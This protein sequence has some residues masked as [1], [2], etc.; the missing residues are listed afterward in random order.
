VGL[1]SVFGLGRSYGEATH[2]DS[3]PN[4]TKWA[5][6]NDLRYCL[7]CD[8]RQARAYRS[9][10]TRGKPKEATGECRGLGTVRRLPRRQFLTNLTS[11]TPTKTPLA[12]A[13]VLKPSQTGV[14]VRS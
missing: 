12:I 13:T 14:S 2:A 4:A 9:Y 10:G 5:T 3:S 1:L 8:L 7:G 11:P 6:N